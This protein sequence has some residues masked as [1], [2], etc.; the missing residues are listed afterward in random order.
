MV[1]KLKTKKDKKNATFTPTNIINL[2]ILYELDTRSRD[3]NSDFTLKDCL[4]GG[5]K[6]SKNG[7]PDKYVYSGY[8]IGFDL[9][10]EFSLSDGSVSK[11]V[12]IFGVDIR[13][14]VIS[15]ISKKIS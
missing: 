13:S 1:R 14:S 2:F 9:R 8:G 10:S 11:N 15:I 5:V 12:I 6:L 7:D 3:L 4:F